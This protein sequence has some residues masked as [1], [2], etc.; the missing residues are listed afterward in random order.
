MCARCVP[1]R[2]AEAIAEHNLP[3]CPLSLGIAN[4]EHTGTHA[5]QEPVIQKPFNDPSLSFVVASHFR[6]THK[7]SGRPLAIA[8]SLHL[9]NALALLQNLFG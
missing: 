6:T 9:G 3:L 1:V 7:A 8:P 2:S 5:T 4:S